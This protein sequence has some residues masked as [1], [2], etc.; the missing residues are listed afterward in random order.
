MKIKHL[1]LAVFVFCAA[2]AWAQEHTGGIQGQTVLRVGRNPVDGV[3]VTIMP[4]GIVRYTQDGGRFS[5]DNLPEGQ[6]T[7]KFESNDFEDAEVNVRVA[8]TVRDITVPII[9]FASMGGVNELDVVDFSTD[10]GD[11]TQYSSSN[12]SASKDLFSNIAGYKFSELRF[13]PRGLRNETV[14]LNGIEFND[15]LTG[16]SPWSLWA[17]LNEATRNQESLAGVGVMAY[18]LGGMN[19]NTNINARA[20]QMRQGTRVSLAGGTNFYL[21]RIMA[22]HA[23]GML[24][25]GWSYAFSVSTRQGR[26]AW[27]DGVYYNAWGWFGSVEKRFGSKHNLALTAF[28]TPTRRGAQMAATQEVFDLVGSNYYNPNWGYQNGKMRNARIRN[29][30]EPV[31]MLNYTFTPSDK[32]TLN[33]AVSYRFGRNGYSALDWYNNAD[34]RPDYYRKLPS[35]FTEQFGM[36]TIDEPGRQYTE[37]TNMWESGDARF[38]QINWDDLIYQN[39]LSRQQYGVIPEGVTSNMARSTYI[40]E[41]RRT[42]QNDLNFKVS[43]NHQISP[44]STMTYGAAYRMNR[45]EYYKI[46]K[47]LL[48]GD[49]FIDLDNFAERDFPGGDEVQNDLRRP[50]RAV[51]EGDKY[52]YDYYAHINKA[53]LWIM[54]NYAGPRVSAFVA[55]EGGYTSFWREGLV[56][57]GLFPTFVNGERVATGRTSFGNSEKASFLTFKTKA[58]AT[59]NI[60]G[61]HQISANVGYAQDAPYFNNS[62][63]S[64][65]TRN[66]LVSGLTTEKTLAA[67]ITY[68]MRYSFL[69]MRVTGYYMNITDQAKVV[70]FYDDLHRTFTNFAMT[71]IDQRH[72]GIE[73]AA[74]VPIAY[75]ISFNTA[76]NLGEYIY[77]SNPSVTQ[78]VDNSAVIAAGMNGVPVYYKNLYVENTPQWAFNF[79]LSYRNNNW[80]AGIDLNVY[81]RQY[82][83][84]N[85]LYRTQTA[86]TNMDNQPNQSELILAM[87]SQEKFNTAVVLNANIGKTWY[88]GR[89]QLGFSLEGKNLL[90]NQNIKTGGY[91]QS[92]LWRDDN[93]SSSSE[94]FKRFDSKYYYLYG[95]GFYLNVYY[96]F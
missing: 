93:T 75:G 70:S 87:M 92:R 10:G 31:V 41:E 49:Y 17:G 64:P 82:L 30:H 53:R 89:G 77:T 19:G 39:R 61:A 4:G 94:Y 62:F 3:K 59:Y 95:I 90:N 57:K 28:G 18:G 86:F 44:K 65:R 45:T 35:Y 20:S 48:G 81:D 16:Y 33:A 8:R 24:D 25:N 54:Y 72:I 73:F 66:A 2:G 38:T 74:Q 78:T 47:D 29:N 36:T 1:L 43:L 84:M 60:A 42:D 88:L 22:T 52:G 32:L 14:F 96:R 68:N 55:G 76:A 80:Y 56:E 9:S 27:V 5:F 37:A 71:G 69:R 12:L 67:D 11:D 63:V 23:S 13:N 34:P 50:N 83:S 46:V 79:G 51:Y 85:P 7:L 21:L 26:H 40:I 58:G 15:A 6:Y 91:E